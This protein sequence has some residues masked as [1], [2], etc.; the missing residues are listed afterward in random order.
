MSQSL[1]LLLL[2]VGFGLHLAV[3]HGWTKIADYSNLANTF[4]DPIGL[5][6]S[7]SLILAIIGEFVCTIAVA[8]GLFTRVTAIP[9]VCTMAVAAFVQHTG[10]DWVTREKALL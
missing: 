1:G 5:G 8:A 7:V 6:H 4:P 9:V 2:R 10:D 3:L